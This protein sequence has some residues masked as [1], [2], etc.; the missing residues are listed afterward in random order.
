[1]I[2]HRSI[3]ILKTTTAAYIVLLHLS[4]WMPQITTLPQGAPETVCD[5]MLPFHGQGIQPANTAPPFRIEPSAG[6]I[7]QGQT[8]RVD[9]VG[10]PN[11]LTFGGF[12][13]QARSTSTP[14][15]IVGQFNPSEDGLSKLMNCE[16]SVGN[17]VTHTSTTPKRVISLEWQSPVDFEGEIVFNSTV[18]QSYDTFWVGVPSVPVRVVKRDIAP[19]GPTTPR[20]NFTQNTRPTYV[21]DYVPPAAAA[22]PDD[23]FYDG[24]GTSKNCFGSKDGCVDSK[25]CDF[26]AAIKVIGDTYEFQLKSKSKDA[27]YV[28]LGLSD[29]NKMGNDLT[30]EC[31]PQNGKVSMFSSLTS[32]PPAGQYGANRAVVPQSSARLIESSVVNGVIYCKAQRDPMTKVGD[33]VFDLQNNKYFLLL[34]SG[35]GLKEN[36]V[37]YHDLGR[38]PSDKSINLAELADLGGASKLLLRLHGCFMIAAWI[39]TTS[40]GII[41][42]RY[43][44]QTWVGSQ[45]CG[46]D[47]WFAWHRICMVTT[48]SLT[49]AAFVIIFVEIRAWSGER[50]PH[51][52]LGVITTAL[53]FI[54]PIG[55]LFRP[56]PNSKNRPFFNWAHWLGGNLAHLL[57]I[58]TIF[59]SVKL[60]KAELPEWMDWILVAYVAFHV[61]VHLIFSITGCS[62]D[63]KQAKR[64]NDF[65][66]GNMGHHHG[67]RNNMKSDRKM[68]APFAGFRKGLLAVYT[69]VLILFVIALIVIVALAPIEDAFD[70]LKEKLNS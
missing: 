30:L 34:A 7:G 61:I 44:K 25:S 50:N 14:N 27:A 16:Y 37:G 42:A 35:T 18:A 65:P 21:P 39:G 23:P 59:F 66:M 31:V 32:A 40:L 28:A 15:Q 51:A 48:W 26:V 5:T 17:S 24:C 47:Q 62:A 43:F 38:V 55:A 4:S 56:A 20:P 8:L 69:V 10:V 57:A 53:C 54:Q 13:L 41:F 19:V 64:A 6:T 60:T 33:K 29:D 63:N 36:S 68:D 2:K 1:M 22:T 67:M 46:K 3:T 12:M 9:I 49:M 11:D 45:L 70:S 52:I 58:V